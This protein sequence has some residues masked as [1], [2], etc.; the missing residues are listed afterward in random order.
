MQIREGTQIQATRRE[1]A[2]AIASVAVM[3]SSVS[4]AHT[5]WA[6]GGATAGGA[7]LLSVK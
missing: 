3:V 7:Y 1:F 4:L 2:D 6:S 5:A